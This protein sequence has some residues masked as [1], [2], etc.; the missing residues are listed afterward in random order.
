MKRWQKDKGINPPRF[1]PHMIRKGV[2]TDALLRKV[3]E[4]WR[5]M[6]G[7]WTSEAITLYE[8]IEQT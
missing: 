7:T 2:T 3:P 8:R 5:R 4:E 1:T 6:A